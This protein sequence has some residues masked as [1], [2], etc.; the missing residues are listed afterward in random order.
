ML[1]FLRLHIVVSAIF[2]AVPTVAQ[3]AE[4]PQPSEPPFVLLMSV[5][6]GEAGITRQFFGRVV[7]RETVDLAFQVA[8]QVIKLP[9]EEGEVIP[10]GELVAEL[11]LVPFELALEEAILTREQRQRDL[12]RLRQ[13]TI[14]VTE[15]QILD[16][17]T[18]LGLAE[19]AVRNAEV[20]LEDATLKAPFDALVASR[21]VANFTTVSEGTP[22]IR[23][24]DMSE[25]RV[26]IDVPEVVFQ[27]AGEDP[28][29]VLQAR[30]PGSDQLFDL[31]PREFNAEASEIGQSFTITLA[32]LPDQGVQA[33]PGASAT[34]IATLF[35]RD[36]PMIVPPTALKIANDGATSVMR[37]QPAGAAEG[38]IEEVSVEVEATRDGLF[39]IIGGDL[40]PGDE[41]LRTGAHDVDDGE[42]VRRFEGF[43]N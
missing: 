20:N 30:F 6:E 32:F 36:A 13:L 1:S 42:V 18:D 43:S 27:R 24:H 4:T 10:A 31:E 9:A 35:D 19:V 12:D 17:E 40:R 23:L 5:A 14:S 16:A 26:E 41:I 11:D 25:L 39:S 38:E 34:V 7:A 29:I 37:F 22:I 15:V 21:D 3:E 28:D 33:L 2:L 8:G